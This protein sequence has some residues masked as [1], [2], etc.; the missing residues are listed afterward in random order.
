VTLIPLANIKLQKEIAD[1]VSRR[2]SE[3]KQLRSEAETIVA[4]AK[5]KVERMILGAIPDA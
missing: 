3:A 4:K 2:R 5:A 1:E